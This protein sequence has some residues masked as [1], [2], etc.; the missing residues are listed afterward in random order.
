MCLREREEGGTRQTMRYAT[1][2]TNGNVSAFSR[3]MSA[4]LHQCN[5]SASQT[6]T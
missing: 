6:Q 3:E 4:Y 5:A 2:T 1:I